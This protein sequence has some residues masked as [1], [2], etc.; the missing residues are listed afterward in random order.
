MLIGTIDFYHFVPLSL[1]VTLDE[2]HDS[3]GQCKA[4]PVGFFFL[5]TFQF[6]RMKFGIVLK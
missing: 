6:M 5:H 3:Q 1:T 2:G 4:Q